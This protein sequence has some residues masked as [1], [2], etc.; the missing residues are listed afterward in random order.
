MDN[1][2]DMAKGSAISPSAFHSM[3]FNLSVDKGIYA[4]NAI[5]CFCGSTDYIEITD[6]DRYGIDYHL[7]LC[8]NCG[9]LYSN[10]RLTDESLRLFYKKDYRNIYGDRGEIGDTDT[11]IKKLIDDVIENYELDTP[12][13]VFEIGCGTGATL[14]QFKNCECYGV[15]YDG[16]AVNK[17]RLKNIEAF[18]GGIE[19][20]E[21]LGKK[22]DLIIMN[23]VLEHMTDIGSDLKRIRD[24]MTDKGLLY[25]A[26][27]GLYAW[28]LSSIYQSAHNWQFNA[29]TLVYLMGVCGF[30]DYYV[31]EL[32]QSV[33]QKIPPLDKKI[34]FN[35]EHIYIESYL[36]REDSKHLMPSVRL[37]CKFELK[38]IRENMKYTIKSGI[39]EI[40]ELVNI[41]PSSES[42]IVCGGPSVE[43]YVDKIK[44]L[45]AN[46]CKVFSIER[47]YQWCL[48]NG[49]VPD[50]VVALD[51]SDD[52]IESFNN[53]HKDPVHLIVSHVKSEIVDKLKDYNVYYYN[54][55]QR[56]LDYN[57]MYNGELKTIT[58]VHTGASVSLCCLNISMML[59]S[60]KI[61]MFGFDCHITEKD[62]AD[63]ITGAG[64]IKGL[65]EIEIEGQ[66]F[67]TTTPYYCF[68]AQ[69]FQM[70]KV[71]KD[72]GMLE[73]IKIYGDSMVKK[74]AKI[75]IDG[76][77]EV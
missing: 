63:G 20:L 65:I 30:S 39:P 60:R 57:K 32:I 51:A 40:T 25:V 47:M 72:F 26:V 64:D 70:Y 5:S 44:S 48:K 58:F 23:H 42:V 59:G 24:L 34:T 12:T 53:I 62:Y 56:N 3:Q 61:H 52:V 6:K 36:K 11:G 37:N 14:E 18:E 76:D 38:E 75:D 16:E 2:I 21:G 7:C 67:K 1:Q 54:L 69:F 15:D 19:I 4:K 33:W 77:K 35:E 13:V 27:P 9:I 71:A 10:P 22:A 41:N 29:N 49:I 46:G 74:A 28:D 45:Q 31:S 66:V 68:M 17:A 50:Y 8:R 43:G 55:H 73:D